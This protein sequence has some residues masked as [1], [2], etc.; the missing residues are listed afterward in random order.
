MKIAVGA[1]HAGYAL[2]QLL[3]EKL[4]SDGHDVIDFGTDSMESTDYPDYA[5]A[6]SRS[7]VDGQTEKGLLVCSSG[8]GMSI[9]ANKIHGVR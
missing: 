9:A 8:V 6:V 2:K 4:K 3:V 7:V 5:E 1:D